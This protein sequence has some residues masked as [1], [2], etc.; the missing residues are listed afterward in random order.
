MTEVIEREG[1][2]GIYV[3]LIGCGAMAIHRFDMS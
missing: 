3:S 2:S 1:C